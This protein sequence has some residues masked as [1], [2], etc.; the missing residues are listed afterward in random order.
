M[1]GVCA[2]VSVRQA[3]GLKVESSSAN[4]ML[5]LWIDVLEGDGLGTSF[6]GAADAGCEDDG[7][8]LVP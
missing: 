3:C 2:A 4:R 5:A 8:V 7:V 6:C 1:I